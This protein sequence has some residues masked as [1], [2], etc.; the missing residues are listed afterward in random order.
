MDITLQPFSRILIDPA[1]NHLWSTGYI[2]DEGELEGP[3]DN[4][5]LFLYEKGVLRD[6]WVVSELEYL[7]GLNLSNTKVES[8][9]GNDTIEIRTLDLPIRYMEFIEIGRSDIRL[10]EE[11]DV[12]AHLNGQPGRFER[13]GIP[14]AET[15][16]W[17]NDSEN[18]Y[19]GM[20]S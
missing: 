10:K 9:S 19:F 20:I 3:E 12:V 17:I 8:K 1:I 14:R 16:R 4:F 2:R 7:T 5:V 11:E 15:W 18:D 13:H 6:P